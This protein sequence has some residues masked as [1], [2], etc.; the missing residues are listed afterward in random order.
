MKKSHLK[1]DNCLKMSYNA[2]K[3]SKTLSRLLSKTH[4]RNE[5]IMPKKNYEAL[6]DEKKE[7]IILKAKNLFI[8]NTYEE[9]TTNLILEYLDLSQA[10]FYR[11]FQDKEDL[12]LTMLEDLVDYSDLSDDFIY[13]P[14]ENESG[15]DHRLLYT[16]RNA[17][18]S[19]L[20]K[21]YFGK[22]KDQT[23]AVFLKELLKLKYD[24]VLREDIDV[25]LIA[26]MYGTTMYNL[27]MYFQ[28]TGLNTLEDVELCS[29]IINNFYHTFFRYGLLKADE[30]T[31]KDE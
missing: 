2:R 28:E 30:D 9:V 13:H 14:V 20:R 1:V 25:D 11:Y 6:P 24:G 3:I 8:E 29:K 19:T 23:K 16:L 31:E 4:E 26:Y 22:Y 27:Q 12:F 10:T 17:P 7:G 5:K 15:L 21:L 18:E